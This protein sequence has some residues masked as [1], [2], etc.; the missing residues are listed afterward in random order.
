MAQV[1]A[2][3]PPAPVIKEIEVAV[4][5][6]FVDGDQEILAFKP[7][8]EPPGLFQGSTIVVEQPAGRP[9]PWSVVAADSGS[10]TLY[11]V[12]RQI[13]PPGEKQSATVSP[14]WDYDTVA[15]PAPV[16]FAIGDVSRTPLDPSLK[17]RWLGSLRDGL[18]RPWPSDAWSDF[19]RF[20]LDALV[21][22]AQAKDGKAAAS[23][24]QRGG[25]L[26]V[27]VTETRRRL[28]PTSLANLM[29]TTTGLT[30]LRETLQTDRQL[31][32]RFASET[33]SMPI[34]S[35]TGPRLAQHPWPEMLAALGR[36]APD[37][38]LAHAAPA[39]FY[40]VRFAALAYL[41]RVLDEAD[42]W[43]TPAAS[44]STGFSQNQDLG[45]RYEAQ[46]GLQ[47]S[48]TSRVLGPQVVTDL[49]L[50]GSDPYLREGTDLTFIFRVKNPA[51]F[52]AGLASGLAG[53]LAEHGPQSVDTEVHAGETITI[54]RSEDGMVRQ[55]R[56]QAGDFILVSNSLGAIKAV[57]DT[58]K[59]KR[60]ALADEPDFRYL[61][62]R[63]AAVPADVL[64]FMSDA[65]VAE[66]IGPR[67][68]ILESRRML[69]LSDLLAPGYAALLYGWM[70]GRPPRSV[71]ELVIAGLLGRDELRH[72]SGETIAFAP[73]GPARSAW[74]TVAALTPIID[75]PVPAKVTETE[76]D[77]Y[78]I[79]ADSYQ[80]NWSQYM[81]PVALRMKIEPGT[82]RQLRVDLRILP[83]IDAS[84]YR[85]MQRTVG[86]ARIEAPGLGSGAMVTLGV[87]PRA[88]VRKLVGELA[89]E[90]PMG[91]R[92]QLDWLGDL[93][94]LGVEDRFNFKAFLDAYNGEDHIGESGWARLFVE[95]PL[96]AG[97]AV[98]NAL[99]A[100]LTLGALRKLATQAAPG[101]IEW[102]ER[103]KERGIPYVGVS[104]ARGAGY[105]RKLTGALSL[106]YA[107]CKQYLLLSL[108]EA[109]LKTRIGDCLDGRLPKSAGPGAAAGAQKPQLVFA[110]TMKKAGPLWQLF[111]AGLQ[112]ALDEAHEGAWRRAEAV[113]R[114]APGLDK[115]A[116]RRLAV[117]YLGGAPVDVSGADLLNRTRPA[118][119]LSRRHPRL[120]L[121]AEGS[122]AAQFVAAFARARSEIAF[123]HEVKLAG[124]DAPIQSLHVVLSIGGDK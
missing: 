64:G 10:G 8:A 48:V 120:A 115:T 91:L 24:D 12:R 79:F 116:L 67:E 66:V 65:F 54:T 4:V 96:H 51:A 29:D 83:I 97:V 78:R 5:G 61:M 25:N 69:A 73:G 85:E 105:A 92:S 41:F 14:P 28:E 52:A 87:G 77:A 53:H 38:P 40:Y 102:R 90:L 122:P 60:A 30:S 103:G 109:T 123:D 44:L 17:A 111:G 15:E 98:R 63:D 22:A 59:H 72:G 80:R 32:T 89:R 108:G 70:N 107:F 117:A 43:I 37:E 3:N 50:V 112:A 99:T 31:R 76:R 75:L 19:A 16:R 7:K 18:A 21:Q 33:A 34:A 26:R 13:P 49:A 101:A 68:K 88:S 57:L 100:G 86:D 56:A 106:Y 82:N 119:P 114:G 118:R 95:S 121:P 46:L 2:G 110:L 36:A 23:K 11:W 1:R 35:L 39:S 124:T 6:R 42:A 20:R 71:D 47:R 45:K 93:A 74:G 27:G 94:F 113:V 84:E 62:A 81:D 9:S 58:I 55:H 104:A